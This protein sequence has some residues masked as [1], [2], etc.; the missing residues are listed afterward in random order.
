[1]VL[2]YLKSHRAPGVAEAIAR[3]GVAVWP[4]PPYHP[5]DTPIE[6]MNSKVTTDLRQV[7]ARAT[8]SLY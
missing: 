2:D 4:L 6:E 8:S 7:A 1:M 3:A 5:D